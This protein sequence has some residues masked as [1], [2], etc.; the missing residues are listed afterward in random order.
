MSSFSLAQNFDV[1]NWS[2]DYDNHRQGLL[3]EEIRALCNKINAKISAVGQGLT[4]LSEADLRT[5]KTMVLWIMSHKPYFTISQFLKCL[6]ADHEVYGSLMTS[7]LTPVVCADLTAQVTTLQGQINTFQSEANQISILEQQIKKLQA[8]NLANAKISNSGSISSPAKPQHTVINRLRSNSTSFNQAGFDTSFDFISSGAP[9]AFAP[10][11]VT[12]SSSLPTAPSAPIKIDPNSSVNDQLSALTLACTVLMNKANQPPVRQVSIS[13]DPELYSMAKHGTLREYADNYYGM[14]TR[15]QGLTERESTLF[16]S[17]AFHKQIHRSHI[18]HIAKN[19]SDGSPQ[20]DLLYPL[21]DQIIKDLKLNQESSD[22]LQNRYN[23]FKICQKLPMDE[24]FLRVYQARKIGWPTESHAICIG[25]AKKKFV[26]KLVGAS[27]LH[28][29]VTNRAMS[30]EWI[31][32]TSFYEVTIILRE[33]ENRYHGS[34][35]TSVGVNQPTK[36]E[37]NN[38]ACVPC[39]VTKQIN[40]I[41]KQNQNHNFDQFAPVFNNIPDE[42]QEQCN[43]TSSKTCKNPKC[44]K[45]FV[46]E[47]PKYICCDMDCYK[48]FRSSTAGKSTGGSFRKRSSGKKNMN[49]MPNPNQGSAEAEPPAPTPAPRPSQASQHVPG[50]NNMS[51]VNQSS[52]NNGVSPTYITPAH[53]FSPNCKIPF[54]ARNSLYDTGASPTLMTFDTMQKAGLGHLLVP[55][56]S[57][58]ALAGDQTPMLGYRGYVLTELAVEDSIGYITDSFKKRILVFDKLNHDFIVGQDSMLLGTRST[59]LFPHLNKMLINPTIR[60]IRKFNN[61]TAE[62]I[63]SGK[64]FNN[65]ETCE[66]DDDEDI[67]GDDTTVYLNVPCTTFNNV[68]LERYQG[69]VSEFTSQFMISAEKALVKPKTPPDRNICNTVSVNQVSKSD[70]S[71]IFEPNSPLSDVLTEGG[72]DG[73]I[74]TRNIKVS[75]TRTIETSKGTITVGSQ[76]SP[77]MTTKFK[78]YVDD[79]KGDVFDNKTLGKTK[80][81]CHPELKPDAK[82][83]SATPKYMPLNDFMKS[84]AKGLVDKMVDLGVLVESTETA[85][86]TI[87]IVQKSS[88]KWR[89]ICDLRK[90]NERLTDYVVHLPSPFELIN[91]ICQFELFSYCDFPDAYFNIPMSEES[92]KSNPIVASVAGQQKNYKFIRMAQGLKPATAMFVNALN[93][94]Y[95]PIMDFTFNYL[96]DS[97]IGSSNDEELHFTRLKR[98]IELTQNAGL[99]LSCTKSVFFAVDLTFLNYTVANKSWSLSD[100]QR[101]TINAL[102]A[103]NL[104]K[105]KRESLAAF[106]Q[107]FNKFDTGV[108]FAS[109]KIRDPEVSADSVKSFLDNIKKKLVSSPAL[110]SVNFT[111]DL[112]IFTDASQFDCSGVILQKGKNGTEL[113][114]CFSRKFPL[115]VVN[116]SIY[117]KELWTLHQVTKTFRY[118]FLGNHRKI[119]YQDNKA[120]LAAQKSKAPSLNCLFNTIETTF[121]NVIFKFTPTDKNASDC[122]TR[123]D[124]VNNT[125]QPLPSSLADKIL[126][127][128][129]N[130]GCSAADKILLTFQ[131]FERDCRL[132]LKDVEE[133]LKKCTAC[134][135]IRNHKKPRKSSPGITV[136]KEVTCQETIFIDHKQVMNKARSKIMNANHANDP[137]FNS[138]SDKQSCLTVFE[139]VSKLVW[140]YPVATYSAEN[141][142]EA[143]RTYIMQNGPPVN[144]VSDNALSFKAL[145]SWLQTQFKAKLHC[146]SAYHP[147]SNLSERSHREFEKVVKI[148]DAE[149]QGYMF[150]NWKDA[151]SRACVAL[152]S[153]RHDLHKMSAYEIHKN[154]IQCDVDPVK[155]HPV[156]L[157]HRVQFERFQEKVE[158]IYKSKLKIKLPEF[159]KGQNIKVEFPKQLPRFGVITST[160]DHCFKMAVQVKFGKDKPVSVSKNFICLPRYSD[161]TSSETAAAPDSSPAPALEAPANDPV[162]VEPQLSDLFFPDTEHFSPEPP[163]QESD[164]TPETVQLPSSESTNT[165]EVDERTARR[166]LRNSKK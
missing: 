61:M 5:T 146:T 85:N 69:L 46:P 130:A 51:Q 98:F 147:N 109:R 118:L 95:A 80:Q 47:R 21:I 65:I 82:A 64:R 45:Q 122:F 29:Y 77:S 63:R 41:S 86:S 128:H 23:N 1:V 119:F 87:F 37:C 124:H 153:L 73:L 156:G 151:L 139:P 101:A 53:L 11:P 13:K 30:P 48:A 121:S 158:R 79:Y 66:P 6:D 8:Q 20:Y 18:N 55:C 28:S 62:Q 19:A 105:Q 144:V 3:Q 111:D 154:R 7:V 42:T 126:K 38:F 137:N 99:K 162:T 15:S 161:A 9:A 68:A 33:I 90:Y 155:F 115:S 16:F 89:L 138:G 81:T 163:A 136:A 71:P 52:N 36:M 32:A 34:N 78:K 159:R 131:G 112:H 24:E 164:D 35:H 67:L 113:V 25:F 56:S 14:W 50:M 22:D 44:E 102:N 150:E 129:Y 120:V 110:R 166:N 148:Y 135:D 143:L 127:I 83:F 2:F 72:L 132:T 125:S 43:N 103:D 40:N 54:I 160:A 74:E 10:P 76:L 12:S 104:T 140:I 133:V 93:E 60:M 75:D 26:L 57:K 91:Q 94:I 96:D 88:G 157:E 31:N 49:N 134:Q 17:L 141:V 149:T 106:I 116:K 145:D 108:A 97:V 142:K 27:M 92:L 114:S 59:S 152:N 100:N 117:E 39:H 70:N 107:H 84:E 123:I 165:P 58:G 4:P